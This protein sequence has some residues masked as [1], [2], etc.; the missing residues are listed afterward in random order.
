MKTI[1]QTA[2]VSLATVLAW[3][4]AGV[5][6]AQ[7]TS[8]TTPGV[9]NTGLGGDMMLNVIILAVSAVVALAGLAYFGR[10]WVQA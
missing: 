2:K 3:L 6:S 5:A 9:P 10:K 4:V 8:T 7:T 1:K